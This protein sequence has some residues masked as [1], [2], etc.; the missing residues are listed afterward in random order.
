M[1]D[2]FIT[3]SSRNRING[4]VS[5]FLTK[6]QRQKFTDGNY[7]IKLISASI[8]LSFYTVNSTN[9]TIL[10]GATPYQMSY[11]KYSAASICA[12][13]SRIFVLHNAIDASTFVVNPSTGKL[14]IVPSITQ[15]FNSGTAYELLGISNASNISLIATVKYIGESI[16]KLNGISSFYVRAPGLVG[17]S[18]SDWPN[19]P[20]D[21]LTCIDVTEDHLNYS[22]QKYLP[23]QSPELPLVV[24]ILS[25]IRIIL[26]DERNQEVDL[27]N[28]DTSFTF[29]IQKLD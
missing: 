3:V 17:N 19:L 7:S 15:S 24:R 14:E 21:F 23:N 2:I 8:P 20:N 6:V 18:Y 25:D 4:S 10:I 28:Q 11:G 16:V 1:S 26:T 5:N 13:L 29:I 22:I 12:E 9:N 27:N